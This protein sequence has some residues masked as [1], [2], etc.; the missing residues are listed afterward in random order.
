MSE[1]IK[2]WRPPEPLAITILKLVGLGLVVT[3]PTTFFSPILIYGL[4][5]DHLG[6]KINR[7]DAERAYSKRQIQ[8]SLYYL[9][10]KEFIAFPAKES[11]KFSLTR[12]GRKRLSAVSFQSLEIKSHPWDGRWRLLTFD[13]P[14]KEESASH[15]F[16]RKLKELGFFH[17]QRSVFLFPYKCEKE[18]N[19]IT[20][21]LNIASC[22]HLITAD[23]F[24]SDKL[25]VKK[26]GPA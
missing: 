3:A 1:P 25:L 10:R 15:I 7:R 23:R 22:V 19:Q 4:I 13:I 26:F 5:R 9:K 20:E 11:G 14:K 17:F 2:K 12:L 6:H 18:I 21:Y 8:R 24:P 16:R